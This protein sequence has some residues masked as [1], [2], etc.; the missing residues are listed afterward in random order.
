MSENS[1]SRN[2]D[3]LKLNKLTTTTVMMFKGVRLP[4]EISRH[5]T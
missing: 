2:V 5:K 4:D 3:G 1:C